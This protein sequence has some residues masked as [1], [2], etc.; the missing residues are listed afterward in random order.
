MMTQLRIEFQRRRKAET[1]SRASVEPMGDGVQLALSIAGEVCPIGQV[2]AQQYRHM[3]EFLRDP[4]AGTSRICPV[5]F[6]QDNQTR[7]SLHQSLD[8]R[9]IAR[10]LEEV[11]FPVAGHGM[12]SHLDG[13]VGDRRD[14]GKLGRVGLSLGDRGRRALRACRSVASHSFRR[15]PRGNAYSAA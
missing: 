7:R 1:F 11:A 6:G 4:L 3:S 5:H 15:I 9:A 13:A 2:L 10:P 12:G 14:V 8:G